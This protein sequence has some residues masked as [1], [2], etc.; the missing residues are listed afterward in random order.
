MQSV[1][2][3]GS[4]AAGMAT[5]LSD[6]AYRISPADRAAVAERLPGLV[7]ELRPLAQLW[8]PLAASS[9][10]MV[11]L[12]GAVKDDLFLAARR[13]AGPR[14]RS[15]SLDDIDDH[16]WDWNLWLGSKRLRGLGELVSAELTK[17]WVHL[18]RSLGATRPPATQQRA[19]TDY[20]AHPR[21]A[22]RVADGP[23]LH[24]SRT[25]HCAGP[26]RR[27]A[28]FIMKKARFL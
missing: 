26:A 7:G 24:H 15:A 23:G 21:E 14:T 18:L 3:V 4:R 13:P 16:F 10:Y 27:Y 1:Q 5:V 6:W 8:D 17:M 9:V 2:L 22:P 12:P 28:E 25:A 11:V 19:I 20:L